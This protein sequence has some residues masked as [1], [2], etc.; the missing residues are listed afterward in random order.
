MG[1]E[2][3]HSNPRNIELKMRDPD[4][5]RLGDAELGSRQVAEMLLGW[6][7]GL[8][9]EGR[10][11]HPVCRVA[12]EV[13]RVELRRDGWLFVG[14]TV[15]TEAQEYLV[16]R[17]EI[18]GVARLSD[19]DLCAFICYFFSNVPVMD[20]CKDARIWLRRELRQV[21]VRH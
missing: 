2:L 4:V 15:D 19:R 21:C 5:V 3:C 6:I 9:R 12:E 10:I 18:E 13:C 1:L 8:W 11:S 20:E 14:G 7:R 16:P 17:W